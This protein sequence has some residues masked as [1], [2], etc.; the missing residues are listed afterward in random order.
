MSRL[1]ETIAA[2]EANGIYFDDVAYTRNVILQEIAISL[3]T[4]ADALTEAKE[5]DRNKISK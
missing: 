3:A 4:I 1:D 5:H 2:T